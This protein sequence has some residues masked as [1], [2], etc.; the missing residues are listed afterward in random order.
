MKAIEDIRALRQVSALK[1]RL[2]ECAYLILF[3]VLSD[4]LSYERM[5]GNLRLDIGDLQL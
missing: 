4:V 1:G 3:L 5:R 2:E